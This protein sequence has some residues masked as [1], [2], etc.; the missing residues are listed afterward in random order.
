VLFRSNTGKVDS[1]FR[2]GIVDTNWNENQPVNYITPI[3]ENSIVPIW[4]PSGRFI[5]YMT[6]LS[7]NSIQNSDFIPARIVLYDT[8]SKTKQIISEDAGFTEGA[9]PQFSF[10][11]DE[12]YFYYTAIRENGTG[13]IIQVDLNSNFEKRILINDSNLD[14]RLPLYCDKLF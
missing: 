5:V 13:T 9:Y 1:N 3:Y 2:V 11:K 7:K 14:A 6:L 10:S 4:S 12:R 8:K